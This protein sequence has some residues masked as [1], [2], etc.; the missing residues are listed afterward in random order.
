M[1]YGSIVPLTA[2]E[3]QSPSCLLDATAPRKRTNDG[4]LDQ[5]AGDRHQVRYADLQNFSRL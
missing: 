1:S 3:S 4:G 2:G 5:I